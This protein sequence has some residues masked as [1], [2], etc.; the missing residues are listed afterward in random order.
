MPL[1]HVYHPEGAWTPDDKRSLA[2]RI[3]ALYSRLPKFYVGVVF[4]A[5]AKDS[6]FIGGE[7]RADFVRIWIDHI[8]RTLPTPEIRAGG[9][10]AATRPSRP[11]C[12]TAASTGS[13]TSTRPRPSSGRSRA[14]ARRRR[15]GGRS[16]LARREPRLA[17]RRAV[18]LA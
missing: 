3:T 6:F 10:R 9:S 16:A 17:A 18:E 4:Q 5:V 1:W 14:T 12:A 7:P 11:S 13:T 8:A 15:I 2:E